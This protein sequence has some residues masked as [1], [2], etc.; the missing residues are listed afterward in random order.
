[1]CINVHQIISFITYHKWFLFS[2]IHISHFAVKWHQG[3]IQFGLQDWHTVQDW[4]HPVVLPGTISHYRLWSINWT[5]KSVPIE[6]T[7]MYFKNCLNH[8]NIQ[9][10][11]ISMRCCRK[12]KLWEGNYETQN[13]VNSIVGTRKMNSNFQ[14]NVK[15]VNTESRKSN[16]FLWAFVQGRM[17][18]V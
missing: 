16:I 15:S 3:T 6:P 8:F 14:E 13:Q 1:M 10:K 11:E 5:L 7:A 12:Q 9:F 2:F 18:S 4:R 17:K